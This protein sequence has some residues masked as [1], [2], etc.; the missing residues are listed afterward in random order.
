MELK[1][2]HYKK[3]GCDTFARMRANATYEEAVGFL[4]YNIDK[5]IHRS[6]GQDKDD[7]RKCH[8]YLSEWEWWLDSENK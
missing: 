7:L 1:D 3:Q 4:K 6:K 5:Y 2:E 8:A